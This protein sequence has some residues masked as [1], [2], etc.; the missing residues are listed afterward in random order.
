MTT[1]LQQPVKIPAEISNADNNLDDVEV[2]ASSLYFKSL[3]S[4][5][6]SKGQSATGDVASPWR[7]QNL[8][9]RR[10][11]GDTIDRLHGHARRIER[12][13]PNADGNEW[14]SIKRRRV[15]S[16]SM[17]VSRSLRPGKPMKSSSWRPT[18]LGKELPNPSPGGE[19]GLSI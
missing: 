9:L 8:A 7:K 12:A 18:P 19:P 6:G 16:G 2:D 5:E 4:F 13:A 11:I 14:R 3:S 10:H 15:P 1:E 17:K